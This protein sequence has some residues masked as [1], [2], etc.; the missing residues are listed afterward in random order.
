LLLPRQ[1]SEKLGK[2]RDDDLL[3]SSA[4]DPPSKAHI[5]NM[6]ADTVLCDRT[7]R[8]EHVE[9]EA[10]DQ[11]DAEA[12]AGAY[13]NNLHKNP[14]NPASTGTETP[15]ELVMEALGFHNRYEFVSVIFC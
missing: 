13:D 7:K 11:G 12:E 9:D 14:R 2:D 15:R 8:P 5:S 1:V 6:E 4:F 3:I 10:E